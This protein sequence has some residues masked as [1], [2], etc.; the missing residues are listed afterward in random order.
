MIHRGSHFLKSSCSYIREHMAQ[1]LCWQYTDSFC[2]L[3]THT[4][5]PQQW[6]SIKHI[7]FFFHRKAVSVL[8]KHKYSQF[9][10][11]ESTTL[12]ISKN[13]QS[14]NVEREV[15]HQFSCI[16][17]HGCFLSG[18][19]GLHKRRCLFFAC[20]LAESVCHIG[21]KVWGVCV[22]RWTLTG[23]PWLRWTNSRGRSS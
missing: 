1:L 23:L 20:Q 10:C 16:C 14:R 6:W 3:W 15:C 19:Y 5:S 11:T 21:V 17:A 8:C 2:L 18:F 4:Q 22:G 9:S 13:Q 7:W 12:T